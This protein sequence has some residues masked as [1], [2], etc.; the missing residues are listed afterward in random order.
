[1]SLCAS[2]VAA[3]PH[4]EDDVFLGVDIWS[5]PGV[6]SVRLQEGASVT[7]PRTEGR[8]DGRT[9]MAKADPP[10]L[11]PS[12]SPAPVPLAPKQPIIALTFDIEHPG[13]PDAALIL[14]ALKAVGAHATFFITGIY[15]KYDPALVKRIADEGHDI[16]NHT[17]N[18]RNLLTISKSR[19]VSEI[20]LGETAI[21]NTGVTSRY[22]R[23]PYGSCNAFVRQAAEDQGEPLVKWTLD[24]R[25][26]AHGDPTWLTDRLAKRA[27]NADIVLFHDKKITAEAM[28][29][30]LKGLQD[31]GFTCTTLTQLFA[32]NLPAPGNLDLR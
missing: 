24:S 27:R 12:P 2:A 14:D 15:A 19:V 31:R 9:L 16:G 4:G 28:P 17:M 18:H 6:V 3:G 5:P 21:E 20:Q 23:P 1:M 7:V 25:D 29:E 10:D 30:I 11:S 32:A 8:F 22:F 26:W 13:T